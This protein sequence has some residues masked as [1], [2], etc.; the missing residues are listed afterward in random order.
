MSFVQ[1]WA[2]LLGLLFPFRHAKILEC[3]GNKIGQFIRLDNEW[4]SKPDRHW[5]WIQV[6]VDLKDGLL[7]E[8]ELV[9]E[10]YSWFQRLLLVNLFHMLWVS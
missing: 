5:A 3:I 7:D 1:I 9:L 4:E 8:I 6:E 2:I 10:G